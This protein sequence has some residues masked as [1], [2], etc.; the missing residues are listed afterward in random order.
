MVATLLLLPVNTLRSVADAAAPPIARHPPV[1]HHHARASAPLPRHRELCQ[2][3][4]RYNTYIGLIL[5]YQLI[6]LPFTIWM[7]RSFFMEVPLEIQA[8]AQ[9]DGWSWLGILTRVILPLSVP[10]SQ[11]PSSWDSCSAGTRSTTR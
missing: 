4:G 10:G 5:A 11:S 3:V 2:R 7:L 9:I 6:T 1:F 8:A